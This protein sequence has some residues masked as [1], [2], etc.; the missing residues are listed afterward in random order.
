M[1]MQSRNQYLKDLIEKRGYPLKS[2]RGKSQLLNEYCQSYQENQNR[3][4]S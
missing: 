4:L 3:S 2:K 1:N